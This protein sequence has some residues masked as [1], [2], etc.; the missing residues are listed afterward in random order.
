M[1]RWRKYGRQLAELSDQIRPE[2]LSYEAEL[3]AVLRAAEGETQRLQQR[4]LQQRRDEGEANPGK[5][6]LGDP[7]MPEQRP[8][9]AA[10]HRDE[11]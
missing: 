9:R 2:I 4:R 11:L 10:Q 7:A 3:A 5:D 8:A 6:P 1:G